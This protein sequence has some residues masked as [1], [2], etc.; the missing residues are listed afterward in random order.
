M[1]TKS[2]GTDADL[3]GSAVVYMCKK[4]LDHGDADRNIAVVWASVQAFYRANRTRCRLSRLTMN[5]VKHEPFPKLSAKAVETRDLLPAL[6]FFFRDWVHDG[7]CAWF[8]RLLL[9]SVRL[10][11]LVFGNPGFML[12][13]RERQLFRN[14]VFEY[15]QSL[16][17][18][19]HHF[20][21]SGEAYC[22]YTVKNHYLLHWGLIVAKDGFSPRVA[23]CYQGEDFMGVVKSLAIA[24]NRGIDSAKLVD[25]ILAKYIQGLDLLLKHKAR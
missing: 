20:H 22:N 16:T 2:L 21:Q 15:H 10:D 18:L 13:V 3:V 5:M 23:F 17:T 19:A 25:K 24:S 7:V 9:L 12:S 14:V 4:V 11:Q 1:H 8:H 6:E